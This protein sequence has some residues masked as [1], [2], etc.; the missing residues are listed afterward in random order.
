MSCDVGGR[1]SCGVVMRVGGCLVGVVMWV[2]GCLVG[3]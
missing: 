2:V 1:V 3:L